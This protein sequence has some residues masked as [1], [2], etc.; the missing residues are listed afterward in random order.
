MTD[1][2]ARGA[3]WG[4]KILYSYPP[5]L[6]NSVGSVAHAQSRLLHDKQS[7]PSSHCEELASP[8]PPRSDVSRPRRVSSKAA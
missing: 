8:A 2:C 7:L 1:G 4:T 3:R 5:E 6:G